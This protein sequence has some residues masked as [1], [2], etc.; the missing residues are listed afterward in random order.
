MNTLKKILL[1][2]PSVIGVIHF[3][4]L[5]S[6]TLFA[7]IMHNVVYTEYQAM[8]VYSLII[9]QIGYLIYRIWNYNIDNSEKIMWTVLLLIFNCLLSPLVI[10]KKD[11][12]FYK[13]SNK[14]T[15][16]NQSDF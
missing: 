14:R 13:L 16:I 12:E 6:F 1:T 3:I 5:W 15:S 11:E 4:S 2:I 10:W 8:I 9:L 7:W